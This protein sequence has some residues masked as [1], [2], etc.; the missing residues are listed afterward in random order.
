MGLMQVE[1]EL[2]VSGRN[3]DR[4]VG[5]EAKTGQKKGV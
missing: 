2:R 4:E 3:F 5:Q 1:G